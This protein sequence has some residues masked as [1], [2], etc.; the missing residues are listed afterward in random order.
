[1]CTCGKKFASMGR[2]VEHWSWPCGEMEPDLEEEPGG[3]GERGP[4]TI[5]AP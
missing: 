2:L 3:K 1:M 4:T 5:P